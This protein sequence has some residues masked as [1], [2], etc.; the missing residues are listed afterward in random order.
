MSDFMG[1]IEAFMSAVGA[2]AN[3][4]EQHAAV[5]VFGAVGLSLF[6]IVIAFALSIQ[7]FRAARE[8]GEAREAADNALAQARRLA[9][10]VRRSTET[11]QSLASEMR[12]LT[13]QV[14]RTTMKAN[15][16]QV[17][18]TDETGAE[19]CEVDSEALTEAAK[20]DAALAAATKAAAEPKSLL[21]ERGRFPSPE[22]AI[23]AAMPMSS[24]KAK[25]DNAPARP[26]DMKPG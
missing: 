23:Q 16:G 5:A 13:A 17:L 14:G 20:K 7:A 8:A 24:D 3:G 4:W 6:F 19:Y 21:D 26:F 11:A 12:H 2:L 18:T 25:D 15:S 10:D 1:Y 9:G 22:E